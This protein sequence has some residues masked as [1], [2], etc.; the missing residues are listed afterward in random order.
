[1]NDS[2]LAPLRAV[3]RAID[4]CPRTEQLGPWFQDE[5]HRWALKFA[6]RLSVDPSQFI[7]TESRWYLVV[8][9]TL[10]FPAIRI[11]PAVDD[12][13]DCTFPHQAINLFEAGNSRWRRGNP[14]LERPEAAFKRDEVS[15]EPADVSNRL[16]WH[17]GR[18]LSWIDAAASGSLVRAGDLVELPSFDARSTPVFGFV[19][20]PAGLSPWLNQAGNWGFAVT[21]LLEG[22]VSYRKIVT[23]MSKDGE[24][25]K[26]VDEITRGEARADA[27]WI[28]LPNA[29][30]IP[31]WQI[32]MTWRE[33]SAQMLS[34][35]I[36]LAAILSEAGRISRAK[37]S[38]VVPTKLLLGFPLEERR[39]HAPD[40][41]HWIAIDKI[42]LGNTETTQNGFRPTER[43]RVRADIEK[44]RSNGPLRWIRTLNWATDQLRTRGESESVVRSS[45][46]L[47]LGA[48]A[49]GSAVAENLA[50]SGVVDIAVMDGDL[51]EMGNL[52]RHTL[53]VS[54]CGHSKAKA[55]VSRLNN[56]MLDVTAKAYETMF[57]P[58]QTSMADAVRSY[59]VVIDC[60][61]SD[62]VLESMGKFEW[63][64]EKLFI[65]LSIGWGA[66]DF[67]CYATSETM[68][69]ATDAKELFSKHISFSP[70]L[71]LANR[72][73]IGCWH[74]V[75]PATADDIQQWS[76]IGTKFIR[77]AISNRQRVCKLYRANTDGSISVT[78][79]QS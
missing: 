42:G 36:D 9:N 61:G 26:V 55:L 4:D 76:A 37:W 53:S 1:M 8:E 5:K 66:K 38:T 14:C 70:N 25:L 3:M 68:F 32:P 44:A 17:V 46:V 23:F 12:G 60:T 2:V 59:D 75:F 30:I 7:P 34:A 57:P 35:N 50:R 47:I 22:T 65:S 48:G 77:T 20:V 63:G 72:E 45:R 62:A 16:V 6:A 73:G 54:D 51:V 19:E 74:P 27:I 39:G 69:P 41:V 56:C 15:E 24:A 79:V 21:G 40:R 13:I 31:P 11:Y 18:L 71:S 67:Y 10:P 52:S 33:L 43:N 49:I 64:A 58:M 78:N 28:M 29:P